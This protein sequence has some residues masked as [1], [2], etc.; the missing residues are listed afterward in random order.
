MLEVQDQDVSMVRFW[1]EFSSSAYIAFPQCMHVKGKGEISSS[2]FK[3]T[4]LTGLG[5]WL[6]ELI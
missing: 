1:L 5:L 6:F 3:A 2:S 4:N